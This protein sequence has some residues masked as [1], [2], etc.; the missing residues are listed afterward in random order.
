[1]NRKQIQLN[2]LKLILENC[3]D[4]NLCGTRNKV[5]LGA[6]NPN[7]KVLLLGEGPGCFLSGTPIMGKEGSFFIEDNISYSRLSG[8]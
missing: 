4:C 3:Q 8:E 2:R 6:G 5:V 1:M 7:S